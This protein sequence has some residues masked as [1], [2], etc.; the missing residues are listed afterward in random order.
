M[1]S[2][3]QNHSE[4]TGSVKRIT[5]HNPLNGWTVV[6]LIVKGV[7]DEVTVVGNFGAITPGENLKLSGFWINDPNYGQQFKV[8]SYELVRPATIAGI[9]K[10]LGS[11]LIKGVGPVTARRLVERFGLHT[12]DVI[13]A[14]PER[15]MEVHGISSVRID[16]IKTAW[17]EQKEIRNVMTF[18]TTHNIPTQFAVKIFK[19][20]GKDSI[21]IV[22][23]NPY[24]L[25]RDIYGIGFKSADKIAL[26][27]GMARDSDERLRAGL[28]HVLFEATED[29]HCFLPL[30]ELISRA[31]ETLE[32]EES[33]D[34]FLKLIEQMTVSK[35]LYS[36][37]VEPLGDVIYVAPLFLAERAAGMRLLN[38][39]H[40]VAVDRTRVQNWLE[41]FSSKEQLELSEE[42]RNAII[43][44]V[45]NG[46]SI[47]TG[48][49]GC[50][51]T[52]TLHTLV[53]LLTAMGKRIQLASPTGRAAQRLG[54]V[55]HNEAKTIHRLLEFEPSTMSF[56]HNQEKPLE[57]DF[58]IIDEAS[59]IDILLGNNL[60]KAIPQ[61]AQICLVGDADQ[62]PSVGPGQFLRDLID[63]RIVPVAWLTQ[64]FRQAAASNIISHAHEIN[65]GRMPLF[66]RPG[67]GSSDCY[68]IEETEADR[69]NA[70]VVKVVTS[71]I[72]RHFGIPA[73]EVQVLSPMKRGS[74]GTSNLNLMLQEAINPESPDKPQVKWGLTTYRLGDKVIQQVNNYQLDVFNGDIG[75]IVKIDQE[76]RLLTILFNNREVNYDFSDLNEILLAYAISIH[77]SQGSEYRATVLPVHFQHW[78]LLNRS[79]IYTGLTRA[80]K[81]AIVIGQI[82]A[83]KKAIQN[84][85]TLR[86]TN[87]AETLRAGKS[88]A[89]LGTLW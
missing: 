74:I 89:G 21:K 60:L 49:P 62:L 52:T 81:L 31:R 72:P 76:E 7:S 10:Y 53:R 37:V 75:H 67:S 77:R 70:L 73:R 57:G 26:N 27:L 88:G 83:V 41:R 20:Y 80:K 84:D 48:G 66:V 78:N 47:I 64:I 36:L 79:I 2:N 50:G 15:L 29:G 12:L 30:N 65:S 44:A 16:R 4:L 85:N 3:N 55:T 38:F 54:E 51:K 9:E 32:I 5:F 61:G 13:D 19:H 59:M 68:F 14:N 71:S 18:L 42:Q 6:R 45:S 69:I 63:S 87:L 11:G 1:S 43:L 8:V 17:A 24:Q 28:T 25:A 82:G 46:V 86:Y 40:P 39:N 33:D 23:S 34:R 22:E 58:F 56:K 35:E